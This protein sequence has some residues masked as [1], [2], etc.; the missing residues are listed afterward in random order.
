L[1][2]ASFLKKEGDN[3]IE[4]VLPHSFAIT[5]FHI[6]YMYP[7][8]ITVLSKISREIVY[9]TPLTGQ[10][11]APLT[12]ITCDLRKNRILVNS[13][14][15]PIYIAYLKGEDTDAWRYYLRREQF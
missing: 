15:A 4:N 11:G 5:Q 3:L 13:K 12:S 14:Q 8:N 7:R 6:V 1:E 9:S 2:N 10:D